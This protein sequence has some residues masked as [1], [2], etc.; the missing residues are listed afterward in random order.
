MALY[1][2][3]FSFIHQFSYYFLAAPSLQGFRFYE[4]NLGG[5]SFKFLFMSSTPRNKNLIYHAWQKIAF[6]ESDVDLKNKLLRN[7]HF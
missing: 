1:L 4:S 6:A 5:V 2:T 3:S 7:L